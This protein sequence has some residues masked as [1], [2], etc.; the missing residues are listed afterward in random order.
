MTY[1][2]YY[3]TL[4]PEE[5][6]NL[7]ISSVNTHTHKQIGCLDIIQIKFE[8]L[9]AINMYMFFFWVVTPCGFVYFTSALKMARV[10]FSEKLMIRAAV[11][12]RTT[13]SI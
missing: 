6:V 4:L 3:V 10:C 12:P 2:P 11:Q 7:N 13:T 9:T 5:C 1:N 8:V